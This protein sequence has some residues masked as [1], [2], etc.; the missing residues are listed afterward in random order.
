MGVRGDRVAG[1]FADLLRPLAAESR[2]AAKERGEVSVGYDTFEGPAD[3]KVLDLA[4]FDS[5][6]YIDR[7]WLAVNGPTPSGGLVM[8]NKVL[9]FVQGLSTN[10]NRF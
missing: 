6:R 9:G 10:L 5:G 8:L 7:L 1:L 3:A 4:V 2:H